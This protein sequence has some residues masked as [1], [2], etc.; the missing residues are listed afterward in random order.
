MEKIFIG[1]AWPYA[2]GELHVG[3][4]AGAYLAPDIFARFHRLKGD[5]V[6]M[7]SGSDMHGTPVS[8]AAEKAGLTPEEFAKVVHQ[9]HQKVLADVG[10]SFDL[11]TSTAT[12]NHR[13]V[14]QKEFLTLLEKGFLVKK[15]TDQL[16]CKIDKMFLP[17]RYVVGQCPH[18]HNKEARGDQCDSCGKAIDPTELIN[19]QCKICSQTPE[20]RPT[21]H[22]FLDL[23]KLESKLKTWV[24]K[25][26]HWREYVKNFTEGMLTEGLKERAIT[27][28]LDYGIPVPIEEFKD[29][30]IYV[31]F[32]AV[33]GYLSA[34][35]EWS[36][37][38]SDEKAWE[39]FWKNKDCHH[40]YFIGKDNILFHTLIWPA[41]LMGYDET[42]N[43][44]YDVP[45]NQYLN[46]GGQKL[47]KSKGALV[48]VRSLL[49]EY[50]V[51]AVRFYFTK[52]MP[53]TK[54]GEFS[55]EE[56][57]KQNNGILVANLGNFINRTLMFAGKFFEGRVPEGT[58]DDETK[59]MIDHAFSNISKNLEK[60]HF[61]NALE[62]L[63]TLSSYGNG[64]FDEGRPWET[65]KTDQSKCAMT[66]H[67]CL[68]IVSALNTL[69]EPFLPQAS[70]KLSI[71]LNSST[72][73]KHWRYKP[74]ENG[75]LLGAVVPIFRKI[76]TV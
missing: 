34:A 24:G 55:L 63:L 71:Q 46:L 72:A 31:W 22:F 17:D 73:D 40:Y 8:L 62:N 37:E 57:I 61:K 66:I 51:N 68:Q 11:Y 16:Y 54:D 64:L 20:L 33:T 1:V 2:N 32:E 65:V 12:D 44:P 74:L 21:T 10:V 67:N 56:F 36:K 59:T 9:D 47:S 41:I 30:V 19:P 13:E 23:P 58:L 15:T 26:T 50:G 70:K 42:L 18:C 25:Q 38:Q 28:D 3:H 43:L 27:R 4:L 5:K 6:L 60:C 14:V 45:A 76:E 53:E 48:T 35:I 69:M 75:H 52:N 49:D 7:V 29:K 39:G